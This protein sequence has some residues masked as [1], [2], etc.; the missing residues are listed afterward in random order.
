VIF[1]YDAATHVLDVTIESPP[2]SGPSSVTIAGSLDSEIGCPGDWQ[3]DCAAPSRLRRRR[4]RLAG[5]VRAA[6]RRVRV[7]GGAERR[8]DRELRPQRRSGGANIPL[9]L[10]SPA[11]VKFYYDHD[12]HWVTDNHGWIIATVAGSFQSEMGCSGDWD[13]GCLRSWLQDP[14]GDGKY[15]FTTTEIPPGDYEAKVA[16]NESW[17]ENYGAGGVQDGPNIPFTVVAGLSTNAGGP[18][19]FEYDPITHVLTI[20][21]EG[22]VPAARSAGDGSRSCIGD[23][24]ARS[25]IGLS[26]R[27]SSVPGRDPRTR[28][29]LPPLPANPL[30]AES[31]TLERVSLHPTGLRGT[32]DPRSSGLL[33]LTCR[34][35]PIRHDHL[36][37]SGHG[38]R[39]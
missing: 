33:A 6:G 35:E 19:V 36:A 24:A 15:S 14:D 21:Q 25:T 4:R 32:Q 9:Q 37:L 2:V 39:Q 20:T 27:H 26:S 30:G 31:L 5:D 23:A 1:S 7:Q 38:L 3:P 10:A 28:P 18:V 29:R 8:L 12:S 11:S 34:H 16:I 22:V 13:P 17:A